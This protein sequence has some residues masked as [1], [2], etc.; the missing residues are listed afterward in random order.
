MAMMDYTADSIDGEPITVCFTQ[1]RGLGSA[2]TLGTQKSAG[3]H[4]HPPQ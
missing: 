3:S 1:A 2:S 4:V